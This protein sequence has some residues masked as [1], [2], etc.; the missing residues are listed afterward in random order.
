[1]CSEMNDII[2]DFIKSLTVGNYT[3]V[4]AVP[5]ALLVCTSDVID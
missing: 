2:N 3:T 1:M 4:V 5:L